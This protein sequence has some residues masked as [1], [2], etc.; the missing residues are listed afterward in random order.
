MNILYFA[1]IPFDE[2]KQRPQCLAEEL[3]KYH[4]VYYIEPT[5]SLIRCLFKGGK[6]WKKEKRKINS[7][8]YV[9]RLSG[10]F[11]LH[12]KMRFFDILNL[13]SIHEKSQI[14]HL[15]KSSDVIWIGYEGWYRLFTNDLSSTII[16]DK[17]DD[18]VAL[19][20]NLL[21]KIFLKK[22]QKGIEKRANLIF[23]TAKKFYE[24]LK[25]TKKVFLIPNGVGFE[26]INNNTRN[27]C[28]TAGKK[29]FGYVGMI[30]HWFDIEAVRKLAL[31][32]LESDIILVGPNHLPIVEVSNIH[33]YGK[34]PKEQI[35]QWI[36]SFD[37]CLYP[38]KKSS[39]LDTIDP[40]KIYEYL[41]CNKPIIA[42]HSKEMEKYGNRIYTYDS[43]DE[44]LSLSHQNLNPPFQNKRERDVFFEKNSWEIRAKEII[45][46]LEEEL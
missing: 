2:I 36:N 19:T 29:T 4:T 12:D 38:F 33:Y 37:V 1:P 16:F 39:L 21:I 46:I 17:M 40:V 6:Q 44:L 27:V 28:K 22:M 5:T 42:V 10:R 18:N 45:N 9:L 43:V 11:S 41:S 30:G 26:K 13:G 35:E 15:L 25:E 23:V 31:D 32:N 8:L 34:V 20:K 7:N 24:D 14:K 3:S